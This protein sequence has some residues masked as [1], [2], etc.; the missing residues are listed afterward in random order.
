MVA[1]ILLITLGYGF[2]D[3]SNPLV[4]FY[5]LV[6]EYPGMLLALAGTWPWSWCR[7]QLEG[8][9]RRLRYESW[10]LLHLYAYLGVGLALP[11]QLWTGQEFLDRTGH[12]L[13]VVAVD[14]GG[15]VRA[16]ISA[17]VPIGAR[18]GMGF[19]SRLWSGS[20]GVSRCG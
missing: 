8:A 10:H 7:H 16:A 12:R 19:G 3:G 11:H 17:L 1:H 5:D 15:R 9:R 13:L 14:R 2:A 18:C 6:L 20:A 4:E